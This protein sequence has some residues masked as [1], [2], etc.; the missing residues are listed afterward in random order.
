M[1]CVSAEALEAVHDKLLQPGGG[2]PEGELT[3][4]DACLQANEGSSRSW[5]I[6][7]SYLFPP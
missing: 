1:V 4:G 2:L 6:I 3:D 5:S 7:V